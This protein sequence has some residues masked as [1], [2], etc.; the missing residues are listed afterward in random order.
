M[1]GESLRPMGQIPERMSTAPAWAV[2]ILTASGAAL[3]AFAA[4]AAGRHQWQLTFVLLGIALVVDGVDGPFARATDI[5]KRLP[6]IDGALLDLV[7]DYTT[8]VL[9]PVLVLID[10]PLLSPPYGAVAGTVVA[11]VGALYFADRRMKTAD[12]GFRG[13]PAVWNGVVFQLLVYRPPELVT[14]ALLVICAVVTF[15]PVNFVHPVR[16]RRWRRLTL[17]LAAIW[18]G[19]AV[20]CLAYDFAPPWPVVLAFAAASLYFALVGLIQQLTADPLRRST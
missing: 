2:H 3:A 1:I 9:V 4:V 19:L 18:A 10:G 8:Y 6:W 17:A 14:L 13:F 12:V 7:V 11:V 16:V 5:E 15:L 20:T